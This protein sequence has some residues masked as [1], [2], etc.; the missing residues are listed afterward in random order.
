MLKT[1]LL[2]CVLAFCAFQAQTQI[3]LKGQLGV[4]YAE[5]LSTGIT[6][7]VKKNDSFSFLYGSNLFLKPRDFSTLYFQYEHTV[8]LLTFNKLVP[9]A[10]IKFGYTVFS[11]NYYRWK[12]V[13]AVPFIS[14][15]RNITSSVELGT[16][17]GLIVSRIESVTR[18]NYGEI[19]NYK[20]YLPE[21]KVLIRFTILPLSR[22]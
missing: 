10:G 19:G 11:D 18:V 3:S 20:R 16:E 14:L 2:T 21:L 6:V 8:P 22:E 15:S 13:S 17:A 7:A 4:G 1:P 9:A 12:V 5:H